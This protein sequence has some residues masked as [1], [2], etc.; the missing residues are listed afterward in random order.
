MARIYLHIGAPKTATS[1]LQATLAANRGSLLQAGVLYPSHCLN[2]TAH[3]ALACDLIERYQGNALPDFWYGDV[4]RGRAWELLRQE[5]DQQGA[6]LQ[7]VVVSTELLFGHGHYLQR[8]SAEIRDLLRGHELCIVVYL[9]RQD[10]LYSSFYNQDVKGARQWSESAYQFYETHQIFQNDYHSLLSSWRDA[11]GEGRVLLRPYE[12]QQW[13]EGDLVADFCRLC[14]LPVL[15][16]CEREHNESLGTNQLYIKRCLNRV[17]FP[18]ERNDEVLRELAR[19]CPEPPGAHPL[20][21]H[22]RLY[23]QQRQ[24][25][26]LT[27]RKLE[28]EFLD[29]RA[30]FNAGIPT[31]AEL[32]PY[33]TDPA[34]LVAFVAASAGR[35][36][37][38]SRGSLR[39]LFARAALLVLAE[40]DLWS[41]LDSAVHKRLLGWL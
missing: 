38:G 22:P 21:V 4:P 12:A 11:L 37:R 14:E 31:A 5:I 32:S 39:P 10:Q 41:E 3:H 17:G 30:L 7:R 36:R 25:W 8:M 6:G 9:R 13:H 1:T 34:R 20:Y 23:Q 35:F 26:I 33:A 27:N 29:G 2:G 40:Q 18:K 24:Q 16:S 28:R 15:R 19:L